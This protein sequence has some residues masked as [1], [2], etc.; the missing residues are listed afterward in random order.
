MNLY[1]TTTPLAAAAAA[2]EM[3]EW[4]VQQE[5][6]SFHRNPMAGR[7]QSIFHFY[8]IIGD[9]NNEDAAFGEESG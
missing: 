6:K 1:F 9:G 3:Q 2:A 4:R 5:Q 7:R 8:W